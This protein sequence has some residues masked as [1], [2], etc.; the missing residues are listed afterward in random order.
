MSGSSRFLRDVTRQWWLLPLVLV[1]LIATGC[2]NGGTGAQSTPPT[3]PPTTPVSSP[4]TPAATNPIGLSGKW[5]GQYGGDYTGTFT[6]VWVQTGS[7]LRGKIT[8]SSNPQPQDLT[9]TLSGNSITFGTVGSTVI[10]YSGTVSGSSMSGKYEVGGQ[11]GGNWSA[12][13]S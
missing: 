2:S 9:G 12:S 6:L 5:K 4:T 10:Q 8:L 7:K 13:R 1:A 11:K 3:S